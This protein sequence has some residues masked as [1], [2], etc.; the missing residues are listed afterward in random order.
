MVGASDFC[1]VLVAAAGA[2][3]AYYNVVERAGPGRHLLTAFLAATLFV[4]GFERLG[5]Y[6]LSQL[7]RLEWQL[8]RILMTWSVLVSVATSRCIYWQ[9]I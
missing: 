4:G 5:G 6:R 2:F 7:S 9:D 1:V 8:T 3:A